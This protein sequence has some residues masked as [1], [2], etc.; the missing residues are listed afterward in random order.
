MK[1][2]VYACLAGF[3]AVLFF[4]CSQPMQVEYGTL[5]VGILWEG[6]SAVS[7][8]ASGGPQRTEI[9][10]AQPKEHIP[11]E[12]LQ[13]ADSTEWSMVRFTLQP[14]NLVF[15]FESLQ[16]TY[17]IQAELG[18]YN[19]TVEVIDGSGRILYLAS[20]NE[21]LIEP[22]KTSEVHLTLGPNFPSIAPQFVD[23]QP[24]NV[25]H[26]GS[27]TLRWNSVLRAETY[28]LHEDEDSAFTAP[29]VLYTGP[30][31]LC[32]VSGKPDGMYHY[33]VRAGNAIG[34]SPWSASAAFQVIRM[35]AL[36]VTTASLPGGVNGISYEAS[37][38]AEGG[39]EPYAWSVSS[40]SLPP[41]L[42]INASTGTISGTPTTAG[43]FE[44]TVQAA[45]AGSQTAEKSFTILIHPE[46]LF[47]TTNSLAGGQIGQAY[48]QP[49][50]ATGGTTPYAWSISSGSL[51]N[52]LSINASTGTISGTP[53]TAGTFEFTVQV[54]DAGSQTAE[55]SFTILIHPEGLFITTNSLAGGQIGQAYDQPVSATGG[56]TPYAWSVSSGSLPNGLSINASTG[57]ISGTPTTAGTFEF[58]VQ[59]AD[60]GDPQ[61]TD[62][63]ALSITVNP[64]TLDITTTSLVSGKVG[65][66]Y[67]QPVSAI[68]GT[69]PYTW[70]ISSGSLPP[71]LSINASTGTISGTPTTAGTFEFTVQAADAGS[72]TAE[73]SFT[74]FIHP[75][76][77]FITT[78][79]LAGGQI[80]QAYDQPVSAT[81]GTTPYAWSVSS[82]SL[83]P[84]LSINAS[85]G[86]ISGTP[87]TVGTFNFT[88]RVADAGDPQQT[89]SQALSIT[90][91][92]AALTITTASLDDGQVSSDYSQIVVATGGT[93]PY[94]WSISAGSLPP[95]LSTDA[96]TGQISG[97]PTT[98]GTFNFTV[99]AAD[100]GDPQQTDTQALSITVDPATLAIATT[101][102]ASGQ[103][104][105][106]YNQPVSAIGGTT[107]YTW[108]ISSG[109]LPPGLSINVSTGQISGT[110]TTAGTFNFTVRAADAGD[111][112]QTDTQALSI[113]IDPADL[114]ITTASP[115]PNYKA[116]TDYNK[117]IEASGGTTP[118]SWTLT[119]RSPVGFA[120]GINLSTGG[121]LSGSINAQPQTG[122][123]TIQV[124]DNGSPPQTDTK[125]FDL[126]ITAGDLQLLNAYLPDGQVG[127]EY[128][129]YIVFKLG[130]SPL[131]SPWTITGSLPL[132]LLYSYDANNY[133]LNI[134]GW[135]IES[136]TF[137]FS[138]TVRDS[139]SPQQTCT[140]SLSLTIDPL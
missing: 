37:L 21:I 57:T 117:Q 125:T 23:L 32:E 2:P 45:D 88:V 99:R 55:K 13:A 42:S 80:G 4:L 93:T 51:P 22:N 14:G 132:G 138:V 106:A 61:Q 133:Q 83:P 101:S 20:H 129:G 119:D 28:T 122:Q 120:E 116:G 128:W 107:P 73:K 58:T 89:D 135:P 123:L 8:I 139:G 19:L 112:Q 15:E 75:E 81:G 82:G 87:T 130:T 36:S 1:K 11:K 3:I 76:G 56:T 96:S 118:Y 27:Y 50:S 12:T 92:P 140:E 33:R 102:L 111:P 136:G 69:T 115:L 77:L 94:A 9:G 17:A 16:E 60:A 71:G 72:Q 121:L 62:N 137:N 97:T 110:P 64:A 74:I 113:D 29:L 49:V 35:A 70:S 24:V 5:I 26:S 85:T 79:S 90:V 44:F 31:T 109:S 65:T 52:G 47:I 39:T 25:S 78:N 6:D 54:A 91:N 103:V 43:T 84:G 98:A 124:T 41:G 68:G 86:K 134:S 46:G 127:M 7:S 67:N 53:T 48:D 30:D 40:G 114:E 63:Q 100:A 131:E 105:T 66:A 95:G 108:S 126:T 59:A 38:E 10:R 104:G 18:I 34:T